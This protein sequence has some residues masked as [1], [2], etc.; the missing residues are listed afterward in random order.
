MKP[1]VEGNYLMESS[2]FL[3]AKL[4]ASKLHRAQ[5]ARV[6][7]AQQNRGNE[8]LLLPGLVCSIETTEHLTRTFEYSP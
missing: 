5:L 6:V 4:P 3:N 1:G 2:V 8:G 7:G